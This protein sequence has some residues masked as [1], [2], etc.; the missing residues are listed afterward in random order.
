MLLGTAP[1]PL[2]H[3]SEILDLERSL[4]PSFWWG[5]GSVEKC[6]GMENTAFER[7][8]L[9]VHRN[10]NTVVFTCNKMLPFL[11]KKRKL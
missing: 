8:E 1:L 5:L 9:M 7:D 6:A 2:P 4:G 3:D 11:P 10:G